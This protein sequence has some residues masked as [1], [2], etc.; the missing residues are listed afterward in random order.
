MCSVDRGISNW[1]FGL[2]EYFG[3]NVSLQGSCIADIFQ[4][5]FKC[6]RV[7]DGKGKFIS[8]MKCS[9]VAL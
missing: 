6:R 3:W 1:S 7:P 5:F 8:I 9:R 4:M 2:E